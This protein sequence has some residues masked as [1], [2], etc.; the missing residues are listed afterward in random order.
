[1]VKVAYD[2][3]VYVFESEEFELKTPQE[4]LNKLSTS[5]EWEDLLIDLKSALNLQVTG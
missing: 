5:N 4:M 3:G 1:M 2:K